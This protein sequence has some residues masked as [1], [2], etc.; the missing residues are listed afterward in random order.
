MPPY[1]TV[2]EGLLTRD[3]WATQD[4][5]LDDKKHVPESLRILAKLKV[6]GGL[7]Q[8]IWWTDPPKEGG[9]MPEDHIRPRVSEVSQTSKRPFMPGDS[10][11]G[12]KDACGWAC[13]LDAA[14]RSPVPVTR[15]SKDVNRTYEDKILSPT[16]RLVMRREAM[17]EGVCLPEQWTSASLK[18]LCES[19]RSMNWH[20]LVDLL[21]NRAP[22]LKK[23]GAVWAERLSEG[24]E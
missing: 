9:P 12:S 18:Q 10:C 4:L 14:K 13:L 20:S 5:F 8:G 6:D 2:Q 15:L 16:S 3:L 22:G 19:M 21:Q 7:K 17:W 11:D 1:K 24:T 23:E